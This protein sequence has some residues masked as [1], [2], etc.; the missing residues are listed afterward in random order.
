LALAG[1][2][3]AL[4][5]VFTYSLYGLLAA[6]LTFCTVRI[7]IRFGYYFYVLTKNSGALLQAGAPDTNQKYLRHLLLMYSNLLSPLVA[8]ILFITPLLETLVV[9]DYLSVFIWRALRIVFAVVVVGVR[10]LTFREELQFH[11]NES[12]FYV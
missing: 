4:P 5:L 2:K 12:Y 11:L 6:I 9:P 3:L 10:A 1:G 7:N 8:I